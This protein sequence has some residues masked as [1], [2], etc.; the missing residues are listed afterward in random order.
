MPAVRA[1]NDRRTCSNM[2]RS[3]CGTSCCT[4]RLLLRP[5]K[6]SGRLARSH[7]DCHVQLLR[8]HSAATATTGY[9]PGCGFIV[10][11]DPDT[12]LAPDIAVCSYRPSS[13]NTTTGPRIRRT[14]FSSSCAISMS[15]RDAA[16][17]RCLPRRTACS[18]RSSSTANARQSLCHRPGSARRSC[19]TTTPPWTHARPHTR[20]LSFSVSRHPGSTRAAR[21][22]DGSVTSRQASRP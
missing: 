2:T 9:L 1:D 15:R 6:S 19:R 20:R 16:P 10:A 5:D 13:P 18:P 12:V 11:R 21:F 14:S 4:S 8:C 3:V 22:Q 17:G 7:A